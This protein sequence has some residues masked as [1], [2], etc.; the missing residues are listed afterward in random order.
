M[1]ILTDIANAVA[2]KVVGPWVQDWDRKL[3]LDVRTNLLVLRLGPN[4]ALKPDA[5]N[6]LVDLPVDIVAG[7]VGSIVVTL[8]I[9]GKLGHQ[10]I[11]G[12][13]HVEDVYA[14]IRVRDVDEYD[15][16]K[17]LA[18]RDKHKAMKL[19][20]LNKAMSEGD[21]TGDDADG[22][23]TPN[24]FVARNVATIIQNLEIVFDRAHVRVDT[25]PVA[26]SSGSGAAQAACPPFA[27][28]MVVKQIKVEKSAAQASDGDGGAAA[29]G[30]SRAAAKSGAATINKTLKIVGA[31]VYC[32]AI[33]PRL[34]EPLRSSASALRR[35]FRAKPTL[36]MLVPVVK[37][38]L[39]TVTVCANPANDLTCPPS[40]INI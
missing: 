10:T 7:Q 29:G 34:L 5:I 39:F 24:G 3:K 9:V 19:Q 18:T 30:A 15:A 37:V 13:V 4:L 20:M 12:S 33:D 16:A 2:K 23:G 11:V 38:R 31:G 32:E 35:Q 17:E 25:F 28:G 22:A 6:N 26:E 36:A 1:G 21:G 14:V 27:I 8:K 40:Y